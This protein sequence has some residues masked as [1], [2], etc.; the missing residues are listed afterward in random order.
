MSYKGHSEWCRA[1]HYYYDS[2]LCS[3]CDTKQDACD[4]CASRIRNDYAQAKDD[5]IPGSNLPN[6]DFIEMPSGKNCD[7]CIISSTR[8]LGYAVEKSSSSTIGCD[9]D[10]DDDETI[11]YIHSNYL[12]YGDCFAGD[13]MQTYHFRDPFVVVW[14]G[15]PNGK[16]VD[17]GCFFCHRIDIVK[18]YELGSKIICEKCLT[19]ATSVIFPAGVSLFTILQHLAGSSNQNPTKAKYLLGSIHRCLVACLSNCYIRNRSD[20]ACGCC[21]RY[22]TWSFK[23]YVDITTL[24]VIHEPE[25]VSI[26][27][28]KRSQLS[29][30][31]YLKDFEA[32]FFD[33]GNLL[34]EYDGMN[35]PIAHFERESFDRSNSWDL[36][37]ESLQIDLS[38]YTLNNTNH[39]T[40]CEILVEFDQQPLAAGLFLVQK[41][42]RR[43]NPI[44]QK[45]LKQRLDLG[46]FE[47]S[48]CSATSQK[49]FSIE[50]D[51]SLPLLNSFLSEEA[52]EYLSQLDS[53]EWAT[54]LRCRD[55][56]LLHEI[57][58][59]TVPEEEVAIATPNL[60]CNR[61]ISPAVTTFIIIIIIIITIRNLIFCC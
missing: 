50:N 42:M 5:F 46:E 59:M 11:M 47:Q 37:L 20:K 25:T 22:L 31:T 33:F 60:C 19:P 21:A 61:R 13:E 7:I 54:S 1:D 44:W 48:V 27:A 14:S 26:T 57:P 45:E 28:F 58:D 51:V 56:G 35:V 8:F 17:E 39:D 18:Y 6:D 3:I 52:I 10:P 49:S 36:I 2:P 4:V 38:E 43:K 12:T 30:L 23:E 32:V 55:T 9:C 24:G 41:E 16:Y 29:L 34:I 40:K 15:M 53:L